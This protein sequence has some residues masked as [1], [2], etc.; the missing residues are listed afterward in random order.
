MTKLDKSGTVKNPDERHS[1]LKI[2]VMF[3]EEPRRHHSVPV[4]PSQGIFTSLVHLSMTNNAT[5]PLD[6]RN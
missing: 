2:L 5:K 3:P 4:E 6:Q 1:K